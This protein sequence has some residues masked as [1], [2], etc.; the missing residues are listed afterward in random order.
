MTNENIVAEPLPSLEG[1]VTSKATIN[2]VHLRTMTFADRETGKDVE[3]TY[4][5][6]ALVPEH[7]ELAAIL[8][9]NAI[10]VG[11]PFKLS[12]DTALGKLCRRHGQD[13]TQP[14]DF[15]AVFDGLEVMV[16]FDKEEGR[17][18]N[19]YWRADREAILPVA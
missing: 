3:A 6:F 2:G 8:N 4:I 10:Q 9:G 19:L 1:P 11:Y 18:G 7:E 14:V 16:T 5:D 15:S 13:P 17:D 12:P